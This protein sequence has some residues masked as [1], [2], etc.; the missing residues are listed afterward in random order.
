MAEAR[1][2][3]STLMTIENPAAQ[4]L[5]QG[6]R[7]WN[8][9][10]RLGWLEIKRRYRRT[11][12]GPFWSAISLTVVVLVIGG[13]GT[14]LLNQSAHDYLPFLAAG[15]VVW[16]MMSAMISESCSL[17]VNGSGLFRQI[18][19]NY[20]VLVF[21]LVYRNFLVFCHNIIVFIA[22][23]LIF[24][25]QRLSFATVLFVPGLAL[26]LINAVWISLLLG[27]AC[28]RYRDLQQLVTTLVQIAMFITPIFWPPESLSGMT[29]FLYVDLNPLF[30]LITIVRT[31]LLGIVPSGETILATLLITATGHAITYLIFSN[32]RRRIAYWS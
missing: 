28:L 24:N 16:V 18:R 4:D 31:P 13:L 7:Q 8:L 20:S 1:I 26:V 15:M 6:F 21:S 2:G 3:M 27:M 25:P 14:G 9:W 29:R 17:F 12:I 30:H 5:I 10:G 11:V 23:L 19:M 32:F 22:I